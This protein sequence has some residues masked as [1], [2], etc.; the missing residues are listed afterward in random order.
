MKFK[1]PIFSTLRGRLGHTPESNT[2][3]FRTYKNFGIQI[4]KNPARIQPPAGSQWIYRH[5]VFYWSMH[6]NFLTPGEKAVY[7]ELGEAEGITGYDYYIR[8]YCVPPYLYVHPSD[9]NWTEKAYPNKNPSPGESI[10]M[11]DDVTYEKHMYI[12]FPLELLSKN[13]TIL[14]A[15]IRFYYFEEAG[16]EAHGKRIECWKI[17]ED[18]DWRTITWNNA[19]AV[20]PDL[21]D[22]WFMPY[23]MSWFGFGVT[24]VIHE[25]VSDPSSWFGFKIQFRDLDPLKSSFSGIRSTRPHDN[26]YYPY[27]VLLV[28]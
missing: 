10:L 2:I 23:Q 5:Q 7:N 27:L 19:P 20:D 8:K 11:C 15:W 14:Y 13:L 22:Y 28:E 17:T 9:L 21:V 6:W 12:K 4:I 26:D 18:W 25:A 1:S 24:D 3:C 16:W